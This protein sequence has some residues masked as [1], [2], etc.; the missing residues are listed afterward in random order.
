[1]YSSLAI[2]MNRVK[3]FVLAAMCFSLFMANLNDT[4]MNVALPKIQISLGSNVSGL[5][6]ILNAYTL[7]ATSLVLPS[8]TLGDIYGRKRVFLAGLVLFTIASLICGFAP[9]LGVLIAGRTVQG[10]GA[11]ALTPTSLSILADTF[12]EPKE[13]AKA[14]GIWGGVSGLALVAGPVLNGILVDIFGWQSVFFLNVPLGVISFWVTDRVVKK[15]MPPSKQ[16]ID[17]PGLLLSIVF[18]ASLTYAL[19]EGNNGGW[20]SPLT[21]LLLS[22][23]GLSLVAFLVVESQSSQPILPL[24]LFK[25]QTFAVVNV[26]QVLVLF[27]LVS[28]LFIF[29]LFLQQVQGYSA[30]A[31]G[32]CF[33]PINA[34][35]VIASIGSGWFAARLG[36]RFTITTG[37]TL[38]SVMI[39][40]FIQTSADTEYGS[41][42]WKLVLLGFGTGLAVSPLTAAAMSS[43]PSTQAGIASAVFNTSTYLGLVLG[44]ALQGTIFKQRL[45]S[46]LARSLSAWGLPSNIQNQLITDVLSGKAKVPNNLP[47]NIS[48]LALHQATSHAFVSGL[49]A[50]ILVAGLALLTGAL[51][52][53]VFV[54]PTSK[55]RPSFLKA[56][57]PW[58]AGLV[59]TS[60][61]SLGAAAYVITQAQKT[62]LT[63]VSPSVAPATAVTALGRLEPK[64]EVIKLSVINAQDSRVDKLLVEEGDRV[65]AGQ[66]IALLQGIDK[67][68]AACA[69]AEQNLAV[70]QAKLAQVKA[71]DTK[72]G[73]LAAQKAII[74]LRKAQ[75]R[76]ETVVKMAA[77]ASAEA[78]LYNAEPTYKRYQTLHQEGAVTTSNLDDK[79]EK[80]K[81]GQAKLIAAKADLDNTVSTLE[82]Q[83][84][85]EE[86][87]L[88]KLREV[89]PVDVQVVEFQVKYAQTQVAKALADLD[90]IYV[91]VP[92]AG[93]ILKINTRIGEQVNTSLGIVELGRTEQ[94]YAIAEVY[95]T[96][97]G[98]VRLG[99]RA[100]VLSENGGF[101]GK[102][103]GTVDHIGLQIKKK[104]VLDSDPAAEK[105]ARVVEVLVRIDPK[106][107]SK[108]E[109][110][111]N[112]QVRVR[113]DL[114]PTRTS[115]DVSDP[116]T[117]KA[118]AR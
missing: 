4:A 42:V 66:V 46:D 55:R 116:V 74:A 98:K 59:V 87:M 53:L 104:N 81:T 23:A 56:V 27:T 80:F 9:S 14:I 8:G 89:R 11:A 111:T 16:S 43:A 37:L 21:L 97:V 88:D 39:L 47:P 19:T 40:S 82:Q 32:V 86:S 50:V 103:Q 3:L 28:L 96:D 64:G 90:D 6:W 20:Q 25:N 77:I 71:G 52:I 1:M 65:K 22:A 10:I 18:L 75:L 91:R 35:F 94:M 76:T 114:N 51:L 5:Q 117:V 34:A 79:R 54:Q 115:I 100:T 67:K 26:V 29:S 92:V 105:D 38:G 112:M 85:Q 45:A 44:V 69:E 68:Q 110:L 113:I 49:H 118:L 36:W 48:L 99:Q 24:H 63:P 58:V 83:I 15:V 13:Q 61:L 84:L 7:P 2:A 33:L 72:A 95:E 102:L 101:S 73:E 78:E 57:N 31:V 93:Q 106:D 62:R 30:A 107:N 60:S 17:V 70:Q 108:V 41:A 12:P 109:S